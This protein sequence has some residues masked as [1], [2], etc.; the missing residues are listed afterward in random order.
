[1]GQH[2]QFESHQPADA[3]GIIGAL[4]NYALDRQD[5]SLSARDLQTKSNDLV[6]QNML[7]ELHL[8][9]D[10]KSDFQGRLAS[11]E[12]L[13]DAGI[14]T[15]RKVSDDG[16]INTKAEFPN[17]VKV[18][19]SEM[20]ER[21]IPGQDGNPD[22]KI[23]GKTTTVVGATEKPVGSGDYYDKKGKQVAKI[24]EDNTVTVDG[25][26]GKFYTVENDG[27]ISK[28]TALRSRDGK[29]FEVLNTDDPLGGLKPS[30][31]R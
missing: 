9:A 16:I 15:D 4:S 25:G 30:D 19:K 14:K 24:N 31:M 7:P 21:T 10:A 13:K 11:R 5:P 12:E 23:K 18:V 28:A 22:V 20:P 2:E 3:K 17:G 26:D 6:A 1:M 8:Y 27:R 29:K